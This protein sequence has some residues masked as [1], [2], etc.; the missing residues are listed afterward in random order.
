MARRSRFQE[1][2]RASAP[3]RPVAERLAD[4]DELRQP[5]SETGARDQASRCMSCGVPFCHTGCPMGNLI[6][7]WNRLVHIGR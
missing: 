4:W 5:W 6:P 1:V 2:R 7:E 3:E